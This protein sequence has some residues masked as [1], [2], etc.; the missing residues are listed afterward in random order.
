MTADLTNVAQT[1]EFI[2][3]ANQHSISVYYLIGEYQ[4][5]NDFPAFQQVIAKYQAYQNQVSSNAK[6]AGLHLDVEPHQHPNFSSERAKILDDYLAFMIKT[7]ETYPS[8]KIDFD[9]PFWLD[10]TV[11]YN[12]QNIPLYQAIISE[13]SRVFVMAYRDTAEAMYDVAKE[14]VAFAN[15]IKKQIFLSAET[16]SEE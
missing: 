16:Y 11:Q 15:Q 12:G 9:I 5:I 1:S 7:R 2:T 13:S 8:E 10:D 3:R 14:E 4:R 6:F